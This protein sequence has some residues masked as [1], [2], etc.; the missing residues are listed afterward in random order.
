[1]LGLKREVFN[2]LDGS[3]T[4]EF[5]SPS[6]GAPGTLTYGWPHL[7][8]DPACVNATDSSFWDNGA[9]CDATVTVRQV[10]FTNILDQ[11]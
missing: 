1:M 11:Q 2:D 5:L 6:A 10:M 9:F 3:L 4:S 8:Q 7:L